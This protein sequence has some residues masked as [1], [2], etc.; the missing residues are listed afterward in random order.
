MIRPRAL[1]I[2]PR[3][4]ACTAVAALAL[5]GAT[6]CPAPAARR[7]V[8]ANTTRPTSPAAATQWAAADAM[9]RRDPRWLGGD[10]AY[11]VPL[12]SERTLWIFGDSFIDEHA[13]H[14]RQDARMVRNSVAIQRG[15]DPRRASFRAYYRRVSGKPSDFFAG[16]DDHWLWPGGA[17]RVG[18]KLLLFLLEVH[19]DPKASG[20]FAFRVAGSHARL[21]ENP[22]EPP[23]R[24]RV[25]RLSVAPTSWGVL[26]GTGAA[27]VVGDQLYAFSVIE[28]GNHDVYLA[29]WP[30]ARVIAGSLDGARW[31]NGRQWVDAARFGDDPRALFGGAQTELTV[32]HDA[33]R[34]RWVAVHSA[35]LERATIVTRSAPAATGPWTPARTVFVPP[36]SGRP[37]TWI[38]AA[39]AHPHLDGRGMLTL[40][41]VANHR[42][43]AT[44][45]RDTTLYYPRFVRLTMTTP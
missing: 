7:H 24:W 10:A 33:R 2:P 36:E 32:H 26:V 8:E 42:Q 21:V 30:V 13:P 34:K 44:L 38:Y 17:T 29:R 16:A 45:V 5:H 25:R 19:R 18:D 12:D 37:D 11:S 1:L 4:L 23:D 31:Y 35:G 27:R 39:K 14:R 22:Q 40:T 28:P 9:F 43:L 20:P 15:R 6:G 41:Y 3:A